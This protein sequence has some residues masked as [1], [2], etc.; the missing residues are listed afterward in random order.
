ALLLAPLSFFSL[1]AAY[2]VWIGLNIVVLGIFLRLVATVTPVARKLPR[3]L[4]VLALLAFFPVIAV[5]SQGQDDVLL[6]LLLT[7]AFLAL[8]KERGFWAGVCLG[9]GLFRPQFAL[10]LAGVLAY[11]C[12]WN[13]LIGFGIAGL[14]LTLATL[15]RFG[16]GPLIAYPLRLWSMEH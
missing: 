5:L 9:L 14:G 13:A 11:A 4:I 1:P 12:E 10:P 15:G 16:W 7:L 8:C 6:L 2:L 3:Y